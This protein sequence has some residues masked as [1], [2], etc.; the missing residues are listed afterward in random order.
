VALA[1]LPDAIVQAF[2]SPNDIQYRWIKDLV[3]AAQKDPEQV[4]VRAREIALQSPRL[5]ARQVKTLLTVSHSDPEKV[6]NR[7]TRAPVELKVH[8]RV[9]ARVTEKQPG[10]VSVDIDG[11]LLIQTQKEELLQMLETFLTRV[12]G[13]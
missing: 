12:D 2:P 6:L 4:Q 7:S 5:S 8:G 9:V 3:D 1:K 11:L 10:H 13:V